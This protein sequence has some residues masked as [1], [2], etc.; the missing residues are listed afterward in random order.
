MFKQDGSLHNDMT[1][2]VVICTTEAESGTRNESNNH[3]TVLN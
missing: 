3:T 2:H 1:S